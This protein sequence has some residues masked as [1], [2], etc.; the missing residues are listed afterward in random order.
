MTAK[1]I[2][3][4]GT[5][6]NVGKSIL[7]TALCRIFAED[8]YRTAPFKGWN[9]ALNSYV[10]KDGGE[11][12]I[13]QA[14]QAQAAGIDITVDMQP[15][16]LKPKGKGESQVIK[17]GRPLADLGIKEQ[18]SQY[19]QF[20]L[21]EIEKSLDNLCQKFEIVVM[22]GAGSPAEINI[23]EQDLANMNVAKL[24]QTPVLLV[25]DVDRGGA[26][27]SVVGTIELLEAEEKEL[28]TG[29][30]LN[31]F[32]GD[33]ELLE[34]GIK[35][36]EEETGIPVVGVIPHFHGFRIPAEDSVA[37]TD[38]QKQE[39]EIEIAVIKLPHISNF[40][41]LEPFE[42]EPKTSLKF[43]DQNDQLDNPDLIII[44][45]TK[46]TIDDLLYLQE[47]G[48]AAEIKSAFQEDI[49]VIGICG[50]Y[51]MLG[52]KVYDPEETESNWQELEGLNLLPITTTFSSDKLTFQAEAVVE[53]GGEF[54]TDIT[55]SEVE[56]YEIHMG[57]S[58]LI[59]DASPAFRIKKRGQKEVDVADG[60]VSQNGLVFG[61][62]LHG[63]FDNDQFRRNLI[64]KLRQRKGLD[65]LRTDTISRKDKLEE[66]YEQLATIV[67][68]NLDL[69][70]IYEIME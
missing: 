22:E 59:N 50:G 21:K 53:G 26:L 70:R 1:T 60:T 45:G 12:G 55:E 69:D 4:Q 63:I 36:V 40:T 14:I 6:S 11:V 19:R 32:R 9:M 16:L 48:L 5:A 18:D 30:I 65:S 42:Q 29:I 46:N 66:S 35:I 38:L 61:T 37:L 68:E 51:Q 20:A 8:E 58:Q 24:K 67:R 7:T 23:K 47:T 57:T 62:Y 13:A 49:P 39:V 2:M 3:L 33:R 27:A 44:P 25:A 28:V 15:F 43:I 10:T 52:Q 34:P 31:K 56:G 41:D 64:N 54:F 17:H